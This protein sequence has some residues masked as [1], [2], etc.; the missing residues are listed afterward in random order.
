MTG[1]ECRLEA[2]RIASNLSGVDPRQ[3]IAFAEEIF[4]FLCGGKGS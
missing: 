3:L 1:T 4:K 2:L